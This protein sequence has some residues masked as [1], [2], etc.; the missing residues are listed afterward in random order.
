ML[1]GVAIVDWDVMI[2]LWSFIKP[3]SMS[4]ELHGSSKGY[5]AVCTQ[6]AQCCFVHSYSV[7]SLLYMYYSL[8]FLQCGSEGILYWTCLLR[9]L[10]T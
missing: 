2:V 10:L 9:S 4:A 3:C 5:S 8:L 1:C 6:L 7:C